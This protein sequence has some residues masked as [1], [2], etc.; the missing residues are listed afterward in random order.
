MAFKKLVKCEIASKVRSNFKKYPLTG[1][2]EPRQIKQ[3]WKSCS[4][5]L[6]SVTLKA[7][8]FWGFVYK[9]KYA[10]FQLG[11]TRIL[12]MEVF[13]IYNCLSLSYR[14]DLVT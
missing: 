10:H 12:A 6:H 3:L 9:D 11:K 14:Q 5:D 2:F 8:I 7:T 4:I 13:K 1:I